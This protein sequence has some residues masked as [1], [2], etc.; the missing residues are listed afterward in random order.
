MGVRTSI[1]EL[2]AS[3]LGA[4]IA[5]MQFGVLVQVLFAGAV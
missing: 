1:K 5:G 2:K 3:R 4:I